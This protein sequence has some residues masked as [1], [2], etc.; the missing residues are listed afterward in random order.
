MGFSPSRT[1]KRKLRTGIRLLRHDRRRFLAIV[2][3]S[4]EKLVVYSSDPADITPPQP[5]DAITFGKI[6]DESFT[7][8]LSVNAEVKKELSFFQS[9]EFN[10]AYS[11]FYNGKLAHISWLITSEHDH[12]RPV[13]NLKLMPDEAEITYCF[14]LP[15]FRGKGLMAFAIRYLSQLAR[16]AEIN[17]VFIITSLRNTAAQRGIEKAGFE[18]QGKIMKL[19]FPFPANRVSV[20]WREFRRKKYKRVSGTRHNSS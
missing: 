20:C 15:D 13:R 1:L 7:T 14:T 17:R 2:F 4:V 19:V 18:R 9:F 8:L 3:G 5:S 16:S 12:Q 6:P 11:L 10:D